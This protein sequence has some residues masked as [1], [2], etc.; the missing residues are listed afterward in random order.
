MT[1][2]TKTQVVMI[3]VRPLHAVFHLYLNECARVPFVWLKT[4][5]L[6][7]LFVDFPIIPSQ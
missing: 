6:L 7:V 1:Y 5:V 3:I 4:N 2:K